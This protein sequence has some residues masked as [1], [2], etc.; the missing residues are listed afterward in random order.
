MLPV[1]VNPL[2]FLHN[3]S[4][5]SQRKLISVHFKMTGEVSVSKFNCFEAARAVCSLAL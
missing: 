2:P 4:T 1:I 3:P 5:I